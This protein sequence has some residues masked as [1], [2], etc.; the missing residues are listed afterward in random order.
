MTTESHHEDNYKRLSMER[1]V[2]AGL[3][4]VNLRIEEGQVTQIFTYDINSWFEILF[5]IRGRTM[6]WCPWF[7]IMSMTTCMILVD[8]KYGFHILGEG[9]MNKSVNEV[10]HSTFGIVLGFLIV[11][12]STTCCDRWWEARVAWE[13][14][15]TQT[16]EA[17]RIFCCHCKG[18]EVI[19][20]FGKY[21]IAFSIT[22]KHY[23]RKESFDSKKPCPELERVLPKR[24]LARLYS[25]ATRHR[26]LACLYAAQRIVET[27]IKQKLFLRPIARD[28]NP[29][30]VTLSKELGVC[31]GILYAP[32]PWVYTLHLRFVLVFFLILN[33]LAMFSEDPLPSLSQI[34]IFMAV[35][36]Y[37]FLGLEDMSMKIQNPFGVNSSDLPLEIFNFIAYRD[38]KDL[39][40]MKYRFFGKTYTKRLLMLGKDEI[41]AK[42]SAHVHPEP[43][44]HEADDGGDD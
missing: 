24:D 21:T 44:D 6:P 31:E 8:D 11:Y 28:I 2:G 43:D 39:I 20:L 22:S 32:M 13:N 15:I 26:P 38:V 16:R 18:K 42:E 30:L 3:L 19:K 34:Y 5:A 40:D 12:Q 9:V 29:R 33:P 41:E 23:L 17:V 10:V 37:A 7:L 36:S 25:L 35:I 27:S 14:I 1:D 4:D